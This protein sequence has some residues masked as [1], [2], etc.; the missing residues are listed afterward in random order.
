MAAY[1]SRRAAKAE[2]R[3]PPILT[4]PHPLPTAARAPSVPRAKCS[5]LAGILAKI[6]T[7][8]AM[9]E[10]RSLSTAA[11]DKTPWSYGI[12][13]GWESRLG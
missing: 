4:L 3:C 13:T 12:H 9:S 1:L 2:V 7:R 10:R 5:D 8:G 6:E 11:S